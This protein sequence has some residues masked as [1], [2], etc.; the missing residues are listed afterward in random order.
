MSPDPS[1]KSSKD[2]IMEERDGK[3]ILDIR[4]VPTTLD[5]MKGRYPA[6]DIIDPPLV[7]GIITPKGILKPHEIARE[8]DLSYRNQGAENS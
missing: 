3:E 8:F 7:D 1:K 5:S 2:I 6:F 4:G